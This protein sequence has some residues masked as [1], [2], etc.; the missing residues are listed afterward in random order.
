MVDTV[1]HDSD[2]LAGEMRTAVLEHGGKTYLWDQRNAQWRQATDTVSLGRAAK[3][4]E[5]TK[6]PAKS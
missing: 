3:A 1:E 2:L 5:P 4:S 6:E